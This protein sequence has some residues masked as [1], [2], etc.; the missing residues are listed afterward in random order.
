VVFTSLVEEVVVELMELILVVKV[1]MVV[2]EMV[3]IKMSTQHKV[4]KILVAEAVEHNLLALQQVFMKVDKSE[5]RV[6]LFLP[7]LPK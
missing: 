4:Y 6:L 2:V 3:V 7:I 5:D 1:V